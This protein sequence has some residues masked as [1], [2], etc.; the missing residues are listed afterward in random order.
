MTNEVFAT[1]LESTSSAPKPLHKTQRTKSQWKALLGEYTA[2]GL[3]QTAF[4]KKHKIATSSLHKWRKKLSG[5]TESPGT[6]AFIDISEPLAKARPQQVP[7][8]TA[9]QWQ[10][11][12]ELGSGVV[13]RVSAG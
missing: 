12:L 2:S 3:T 8:R 5:Q 7:S 11:E 1:T 6:E 10:V 9:Q 4:C 13:L